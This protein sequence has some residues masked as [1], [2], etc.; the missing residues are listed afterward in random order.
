MVD[1]LESIAALEKAIR[2]PKT[3]EKCFVL[4]GLVPDNR[5]FNN[6]G[7]QGHC[8]RKAGSCKAETGREQCHFIHAKDIHFS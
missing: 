4:V 5:N 8:S 2:E 7:P 6:G 1:I 3:I